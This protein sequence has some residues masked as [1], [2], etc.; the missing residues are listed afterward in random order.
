MMMLP[1]ASA[2]AASARARAEA[3]APT[4]ARFPVSAEAPPLEQAVVVAH[5]LQDPWSFRRAS[6]GAA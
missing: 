4:R 6:D 5:F 3:R 2:M 1:A